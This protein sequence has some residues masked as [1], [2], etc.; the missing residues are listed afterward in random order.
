[1]NDRNLARLRAHRANI[2][3]YRRLLATR[4]SDIER[5]YINRRMDE[6]QRSLQALLQD[7]FPDR[8][9]LR[10]DRRPTT[11][12]EMTELLHPAEAFRHP[13]DVVDDCDLTSYEKRAILSSWAA[14]TCTVKDGLESSR[15]SDGA[16][17]F[18]DIVDA[19]HVLELD[20]ERDGDSNRKDKRPGMRDAGDSHAV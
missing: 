12:P 11:N 10:L 8:L 1:M 16:V 19:L 3:R 18:N 15:T 6:E 13:M 2:Q 9:C 4:L 5:A 7:T 14:D 17:T 20:S